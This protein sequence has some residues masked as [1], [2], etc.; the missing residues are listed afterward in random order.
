MIGCGFLRSFSS[1]IEKCGKI[2]CEIV[3]WKNKFSGM[4]IE[5]SSGGFCI[6]CG[7]FFYGSH[8]PTPT[9]SDP[10]PTQLDPI[11][12]QSEPIPTHSKMIFHLGDSVHNMGDFTYMGDFVHNMGDFTYMG[13]FY[14]TW[15][16]LHT[17]GIFT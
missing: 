8:C 15:G 14:I 3:G 4:V 17:W 13:D 12:T 5:E 7:G 16:I 6:S 1:K 11:S 2:G 10:I 9:H